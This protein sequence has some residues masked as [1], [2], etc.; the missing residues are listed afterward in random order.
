MGS[1]ALKLET[2][3]L[4]LRA[5][6]DP[7]RGIAIIRCKQDNFG[8]ILVEDAIE[9][10]LPEMAIQTL[11]KTSKTQALDKLVGLRRFYKYCAL[12]GGT[13]IFAPRG[14]GWLENL[15]Y[16]VQR[17]TPLFAFGTGV[18][19][20]EFLHAQHERSPERPPA[21]PESLAA[22]IACLSQFKFLSVR[23]VESQRILTEHG[24]PDVEI[25][26]DPALF[27]AR[28]TLEPRSPGR[29]IGVN[30][31]DQP[32]FWGDSLPLTIEKMTATIR[33][34]ERDGWTVTLLPTMPEEEP[35]SRALAGEIG[36]SRVSVFRDYLN[37]RHFLE[38]V[39]D[40]DL[41]VGVKLHSVI[42]AC[43]MTTPAIMIGYQPKCHDFMRTM[44]LEE[45]L[46]R[47]D[48]L[49][50]DDLM[51]LIREVHA[52]PE[53]LRRRQFTR[54]KVY[55]SRLLNFRDRVLE[56]VGIAAPERDRSLS[57]PSATATN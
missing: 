56:S 17:T 57:Y 14:I 8:D 10:M 30:V 36:S 28:Q 23:G 2:I 9:A 13:L 37:A 29:R 52:D 21:D 5:Y 46:I 35:L 12:G 25:V 47:T 51:S 18:I 7:S 6:R 40:Q 27:Y 26:G 34:L 4:L 1:F 55:R 22:W 15:E 44:D 38:V 53:P 48:H 31:S 20:P 39:S 3:Q 42:A 43:C 24:L 49:D 16:L 33:L 19:D 54:C 11:A 32:P 41:L 50:L 45:Y